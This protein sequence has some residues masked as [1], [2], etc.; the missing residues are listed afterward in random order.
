[1]ISLPTLAVGYLIAA[2]FRQRIRPDHFRNVVTWLLFATA[3]LATLSAF[4]G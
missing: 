1:V 3:V 4:R 2:R